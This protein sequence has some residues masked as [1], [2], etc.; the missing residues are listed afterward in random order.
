VNERSK[1][2][3][4]IPAAIG[5]G[6]RAPHVRHV[7]TTRPAIGWL[8]IHAE[9]YL[10]GPAL[11]RLDMLRRDYPL[12]VH[13]VGLSLG[14]A[15]GLDAEHLK[16]FKALIDRSEPFLVSDHLSWSVVDGVYLG[17]LLPLPY[18]EEMLAI[19]A[20]NVDAA[21]D[22]LQRQIL[23]ENP[24]RYL[25]FRHSTIP[26][27]QFLAEL[28]RRTG[29][30]LLLDVNN[31][32]VTCGNLDLDAQTYLDALS[33]API[34]EIH[35]AGHSRVER[36]RTTIL[37]DDH[38]S[39]V[40]GPVWELYAGALERFGLVPSLIEWDKDLPPFETLVGEASAAVRI[41]QAWGS[42]NAR[43]A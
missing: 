30:G 35:L 14:T 4:E 37:I 13:G 25:H 1:V 38:A 21:Q 41:A 27:P 33:A 20:A 36:G 23:V 17:D 9:N 15:S 39:I 40:S 31:V 12:S 26:E 7:E 8:E 42:K 28:A 43:A 34:G 29:C 32:F 3:A 18:T 16:R 24:S 5:L 19:V 10:G 11:S 6:L 2:G 22:A